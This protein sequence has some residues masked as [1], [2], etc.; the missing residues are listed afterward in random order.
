MS[1]GK[2]LR[3][4]IVERD[5]GEPKSNVVVRIT[6]LSPNK[7]DIDAGLYI[8]DANGFVSVQHSELQHQIDLSG[9]VCPMDY[10]PFDVTECKGVKIEVMSGSQVEEAIEA[11][12]M[13]SLGV[14]E[15]GNIAK[16]ANVFRSASFVF[17]TQP[18]I[19]DVTVD[20]IVSV[21][22]HKVHKEH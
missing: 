3:L 19:A 15:W 5:S 6:V 11:S 18:V 2:N 1:H 7:N 17:Q 16:N 4:Q 22:V 10:I 8:S 12:R 20:G 14:A 9:R 21:E 13:W